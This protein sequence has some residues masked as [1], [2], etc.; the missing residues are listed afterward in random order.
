M[1]RP[2]RVAWSF[3]HRVLQPPESYRAFVKDLRLHYHY[4]E[5]IAWDLRQTLVLVPSDRL[6][7]HSDISYTCVSP[8]AHK[9]RKLE[10]LVEPLKNACKNPL[11]QNVYREPLQVPRE[12]PL[13]EPS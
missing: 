5:S 13:Q 10:F 8:T 3:R 2:L 1:A 7:G 9:H 4:Q 11:I 6:I 12:K